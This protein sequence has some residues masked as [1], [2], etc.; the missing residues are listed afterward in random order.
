MEFRIF[1]ICQKYAKSLYIVLIIAGVY[2]INSINV[3]TMKSFIA[4]I[5]H[6]SKME[7]YKQKGDRRQGWKLTESTH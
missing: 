2:E 4:R 7:V 1:L 3:I 5:K 6:V